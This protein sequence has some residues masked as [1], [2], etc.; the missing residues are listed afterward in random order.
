DNSRIKRNR[1]TRPSKACTLA[2]H[3]PDWDALAT[4]TKGPRQVWKFWCRDNDATAV[5]VLVRNG[6]DCFRHPTSRR[7]A[8]C[9]LRIEKVR[10]GD[11]CGGDTD[12]LVGMHVDAETVATVARLY[13]LIVDG[14]PLRAI[15]QDYGGRCPR[16]PGGKL[17]TES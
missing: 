10:A 3:V 12:A 6:H 16:V 17:E 15:R 5:E 7:N 11:K 13:R 4:N 14:E 2:E 1:D 9:D 8:V